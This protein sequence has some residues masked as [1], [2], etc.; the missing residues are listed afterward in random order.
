LGTVAEG[1]PGN[2]RCIGESRSAE[3]VSQELRHVRRSQSRLSLCTPDAAAR[4]YLRGNGH[5]DTRPWYYRCRELV[6]APLNISLLR[7]TTAKGREFYRQ[8]VE[9]VERLP[10][11]E[12]TSVARVPVMTGRGRVS[13][14]MVEGRQGYSEEFVLGEG[15]GVVTVDPTLINTNVRLGRLD[16]WQ[17]WFREWKQAGGRK[18]DA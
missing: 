5:C 7:Y 15:V 8:V 2:G 6:A 17:Q 3:A 10:G 13:G 1:P 4:A 18:E 14:L 11:V 16:Q 12:A 9:R